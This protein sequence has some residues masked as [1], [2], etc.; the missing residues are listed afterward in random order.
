MNSKQLKWFIGGGVILVAFAILMTLNMGD[1]LVFFFTPSE[2]YAKGATI[3]NKTVRVAGMVQAGS[4]KWDSKT[5]DLKFT[6]TDFKG[7]D[8][9]VSHYGSP[10]DLFKEN[11][12]VIVEGLVNNTQKVIQSKKLMVK[13]SEEYRVPKDHSLDKEMLQKSIFKGEN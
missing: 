2:A 9:H 10:P 13:H 3:E 7:H 12:G 6:L 4:K 5:L 11:Q 1:G 8:Y